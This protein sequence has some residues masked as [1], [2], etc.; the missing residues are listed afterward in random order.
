MVV[1]RLADEHSHLYVCPFVRWDKARDAVAVDLE[2][3]DPTVPWVYFYKFWEP[4]SRGL[5]LR[6]RPLSDTHRTSPLL[7]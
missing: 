6:V 2:L 3:S 4:S 5:L 7:V 1:N